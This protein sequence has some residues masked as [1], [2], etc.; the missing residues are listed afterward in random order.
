MSERTKKILLV[1]GFILSVFVIAFTLYFLFFKPT[2]PPASVESDETTTGGLPSA[3]EGLLRPPTDT[4]TGTSSGGLSEA[5]EVARGGL[6]QTIELTTSTIY[7]SIIGQDG[8]SMNYYNASDGRFYT[9]DAEGNVIALSETQFPN[10]E[11]ANWNKD[12]EKV[13]MEFPDGSNIIYDF[14]T[15]KQ[16]TLP[17]HWE[18]FDFSPVKDEI[19]AKS[20][21]LDPNNNYLVISSDDGSRSVS[22]QALGENADKVDVAWSPN[23]QVIAFA[24]TSK[25]IQ[26]GIDRTVIYPVGKNEENFKGLVVEGINFAP[27]WSPEGKKLL[28]SVT[29][30]YSDDKPLLWIVDATSSTM[31]DNRHSLGLNTWV[32]KC[33]WSSSTVIYCA[34][35]LDL[36]KYAGLQRSLYEREPDAIYKINLSTGIST[37]VGI[38]EESTSMN[39][40]QVSDDESLLYF[41]NDSGQLE[42]MRLK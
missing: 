38:P 3:L 9:I 25:S 16:I 13:V 8:K 37:L 22:V 18:D 21:A 11:S 10:V 32:D 15:E 12:S 24:Q 6:T 28:Y 36:P 7:N 42:L 17:T 19:L 5:D 23:D 39:N 14:S 31:G 1:C 40:L 2:P 34:V 33:T 4:G 30:S 29:G 20:I 27:L 41:S 26:G 35:P